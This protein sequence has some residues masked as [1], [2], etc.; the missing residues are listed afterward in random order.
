MKSKF[1]IK[2]VVAFLAAT[3]C[4]CA[5]HY[6]KVMNRDLTALVGKNITAAVDRFGYPSQKLS[7]GGDTVYVWNSSGCTVRV[8]TD[9]SDH[10]LRS[11]FDGDRSDCKKYYNALVVNAAS[12]NSSAH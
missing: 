6:H 2:A 3:L 10:I 4:G 11:D 1:S 9:G 8:G 12:V 7:I 5:G